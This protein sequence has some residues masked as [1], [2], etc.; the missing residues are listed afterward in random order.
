MFKYSSNR[1]ENVDPQLSMFLL[2]TYAI[3]VWSPVMSAGLE[4]NA[5]IFDAVTAAQRAWL[6]FAVGSV[7]GSAAGP[8]HV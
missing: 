6:D 3:D 8:R 5:K 4:W 7:H 2:P 1:P